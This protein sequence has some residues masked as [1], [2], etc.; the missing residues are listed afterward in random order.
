MTTGS[1]ADPAAGESG[2]GISLRR[3]VLLGPIVFV[4]WLVGCA[5][6]PPPPAPDTNALTAA[7]FKVYVA[8]TQEQRE[9][10]QS[11]VPGRLTELQRTGVQYFVYPDAAHDRIYVGR[12]A[13]YTAYLKL[14]PEGAI[15]SITKPQAADLTSYN[16]Q[17][18]GMQANTYRDL[19]DPYSDWTSLNDIGNR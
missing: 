13:Q 6:M 10:L 7:G 2:N 17:D 12:G 18:V 3:A 5:G 8:Q 9:H 11:L 14:Q 4:A 1:R 16:R 15:P 19:S